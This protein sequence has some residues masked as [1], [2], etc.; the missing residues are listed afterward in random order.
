MNR[1]QNNQSIS[2]RA[3]QLLN[4]YKVHA[5]KDKEEVLDTILAKIEREEKTPVRKI[6][7]F[8]V[9]GISAAAVVAILVAFY[10]FTAT[11][12]IS[13]DKEEVLT[14]RMPDNSRVILHDNSS[15]EF[16]RYFQKRHVKLSGQAYFEV[17]KGDGFIVKTTNGKVQVLG[18]RFLVNDSGTNLKVQCFEGKVKTEFLNDAWTLEPGTQFSGDQT[19]AEKS[20]IAEKMQYPEFAAFFKSFTNAPLSEVAREI[21]SFFDIEIELK[22]GVSKKFS[23]TIQTGKLENALQIVCESLQLKYEYEDDFKI[24]FF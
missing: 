18:T 9:S 4:G 11:I 2:E 10:F 12:T 5:K 17:E 13:A 8:R 24:I 15:A 19:V 23:G 3:E 14:Y 21:E 1:N 20:E 22:R 16:G 7:W 6:N